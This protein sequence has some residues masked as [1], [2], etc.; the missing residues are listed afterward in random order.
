MTC[1]A[2]MEEKRKREADEGSHMEE[3][4]RDSGT[5]KEN[6]GGASAALAHSGRRR[7]SGR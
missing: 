5:E 1:G 2:K 3:R 6:M 4:E 7:G